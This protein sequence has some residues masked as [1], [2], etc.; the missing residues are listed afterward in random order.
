MRYEREA[1]RDPEPG[2]RNQT[3]WDI[4]SKDPAT[5]RVRLIEV[6]GKGCRWDDD[7]AVEPSLAQIRTAF[8]VSIEGTEAWYLYV[9]EK[10]NDGYRVLP[11]ANPV[12]DAAKW[13]LCGK[14]WREAAGAGI[15]RDA[16]RPDAWWARVREDLAAQI[17]AGERFTATGRKVLTSRGPGAAKDSSRRRRTTP[18]P[19]RK[20]PEPRRRSMSSP[21]RTAPVNPRS[22]DPLASAICALS[23]PMR[24]RVE[25]RPTIPDAPP[26]LPAARRAQ[27]GGAS[28]GPGG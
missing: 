19:A 16:S 18:D 6:K 11:V 17:E 21:G 1:G 28:S 14:S 22:D 15:Q 25:S 12:R 7:E 13:L 10:T 24:S 9:V 27:V 26:V 3:G 8:E 2:D 20:R 4:R 23:P 5:G